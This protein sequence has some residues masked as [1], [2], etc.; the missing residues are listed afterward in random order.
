MFRKLKSFFFSSPIEFNGKPLATWKLLLPITLVVLGVAL[1]PI[2]KEATRPPTSYEMAQDAYEKAKEDADV[3][4]KTIS[5]QTE[6]PMDETPNVA[7]ITDVSLLQDQEFFKVAMNG[8]RVLIYEKAKIIVLYRP[9]E[10][11]V[12][13]TA[14]VLYNISPT[15]TVTATSSAVTTTPSAR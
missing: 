14:P 11:K 9:T 1:Y 2:I 5:K 4:S 13:A 10:D 8:D 12:I 3:L 15:P 7:T 6:V